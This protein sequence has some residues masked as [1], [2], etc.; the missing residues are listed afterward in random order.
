VV[1]TGL[2]GI[3]CSIMIY[4]CTRRPLWSGSG[5]FVRFLAT[6]I[7]LGLSTALLTSAIAGGLAS[8]PTVRDAVAEFHERL[9]PALVLAVAA[10][11]VFEASLFAHLLSKHQTPLKRSALLLKRELSAVTTWRFL[12]GSLG[13]LALPA[14][15]MRLDRD[16]GLTGVAVPLMA[17]G[18]FLLLVAGELCERYLFFTA[19]VAPRMPGGLRT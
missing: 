6:T 2:A 4:R 11:L 17:A 1:I 9:L 3:L 12:L 7:V 13:G 14:I 16:A 5:T 8:S 10:K 19:A 15:W 18:Q